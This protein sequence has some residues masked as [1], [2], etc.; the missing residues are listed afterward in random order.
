M[1]LRTKFTRMSG[2]GHLC[3]LPHIDISMSYSMPTIIFEWWVFRF[4]LE[5]W[6][7][8]PNWM[9][10]VWDVITL[11]ILDNRSKDKEDDE[12]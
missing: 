4:D 11:N 9:M 8:L 12:Y 3:L 1:K 2:F 6:A 10:K 7:K 5:I